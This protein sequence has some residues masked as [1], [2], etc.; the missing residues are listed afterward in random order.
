MK[1]NSF[2]NYAYR[3]LIMLGANP[4]KTISLT[5]IASAYDIS[6]NHLKKV[7]ARLVENGYVSTE[8]GR[9]GGLRISKPASE[10]G[11]G[12]IFRIAQTDTAFV[13]CMAEEGEGCVI[14]PVC[15]LQSI[16]KKALGEFIAVMDRYTLADLVENKADLN[17]L[18]GIEAVQVE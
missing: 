11:L 2:T 10:I 12:E 7:S 1:I 17:N 9:S 6:L 4:D 18:L 13:E 16:F 15:Q 14:S 8:R 3:I 5:E